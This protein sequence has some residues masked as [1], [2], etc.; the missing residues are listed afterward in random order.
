LAT[1]NGRSGLAQRGHSK[2]KRDDLRQ[3]G[4]ALLVTRDFQVI[5][6]SRFSTKSIQEIYLT[7]VSFPN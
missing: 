3:I 6:K 7:S 2:Q 1:T 5:F 4:L